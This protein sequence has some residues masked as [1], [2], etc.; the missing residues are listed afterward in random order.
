MSICGV[1]SYGNIDVVTEIDLK[2]DSLFLLEKKTYLA[3]YSY[4]LYGG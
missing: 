1:K 3:Q 4:K 2:R